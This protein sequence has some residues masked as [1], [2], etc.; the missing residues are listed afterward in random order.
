MSSPSSRQAWIVDQLPMR[1]T[2]RVVELGCGHGVAAT[3][4]CERIPRGAY[5]GIDR[6]A[7][8]TAAATRR[9]AVH[10]ADGRARFA[11]TTVADAELEGRFDWALAIHFPPIDRGDPSAELATVRPHLAPSGALAVGFQPLDPAGVSTAIERLAGVLAAGGFSVDEVHRGDPD[12]R[13]T[14]VVIARLS[15][16]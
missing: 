14:A 5:L 13:P 11:T 15:S 7:T 16:R 9:N 10:V 3:A 2:D 4:V 6:S 12:G 1:P 8:M